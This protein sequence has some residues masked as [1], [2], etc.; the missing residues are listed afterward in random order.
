M[1]ELPM[2]EVLTSLALGICLAAA[3][4]FRVF[5]PLLV[6]S[7][8][9]LAGYFTPAE[10]LA[11]IAS[12]PAF[13]VL[14]TATVVEI[15]AYYV[16]WADNM[17]DTI[18]TPAAALAGVLASASVLGELPPSLQWTLAAVAGGGAAGLVQVGTVLL[19]GVSTVSTGGLGNHLVAS[20]ENLLAIATTVMALLVP[21]AAAA[22][23]FIA[24]LLT[25]R[26]IARRRSRALATGAEQT[27]QVRTSS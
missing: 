3:C 14:L 23:I 9:G 18:A 17:L 2:L 21:L 1:L 22:L 15:T 13:G 19:R 8:A 20:V 24:G 25:W 4:G 6:L 11:W 5:A 26:Y 12:W 27:S 10:E 16:P 7:G